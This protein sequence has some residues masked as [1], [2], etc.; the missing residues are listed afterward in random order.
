MVTE[1]YDCSGSP[2]E[3]REAVDNGNEW[4]GASDHDPGTT[5]TTLYQE[6]MRMTEL[7]TGGAAQE[8]THRTSP[9]DRA[10]HHSERAVQRS[11]ATATSWDDAS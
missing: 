7:C 6:V 8:T 11:R 3:V 10:D 1:T 2:D 4:V 5:R 9:F